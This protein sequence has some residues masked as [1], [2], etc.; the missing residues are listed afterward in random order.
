MLQKEKNEVVILAVRPHWITNIK[1]FFITFFM[2]FIPIIFRFLD[3]FQ[4]LPFKY[5]FVSAL[6]WYLITF[7]YAFEKFLDG[8][9]FLEKKF[10]FGISFY[11]FNNKLSTKTVLLQQR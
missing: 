10:I 2:L 11:E 8:I 7:I 3:L 6:F 1:W 5:Q 9:V 4:S